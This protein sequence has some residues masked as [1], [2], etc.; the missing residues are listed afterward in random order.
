VSS[1]AKLIYKKNRKKLSST[2]SA[3]SWSLKCFIMFYYD[4]IQFKFCIM[5][6]V[7]RSKETYTSVKRDLH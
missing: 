5:F 1:C 2:S 7:D 3:S 4:I 6:Y